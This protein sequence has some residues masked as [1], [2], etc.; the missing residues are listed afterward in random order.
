MRFSAADRE[1]IR[2]VGE[3]FAKNAMM[4]PRDDR[5]SAACYEDDAIML[6]PNQAPLNG[7]AAIE[8]FLSS[9]PPFSDYQLEVAEI[10]GDG[11]LAYERGSASMTLSASG[12]TSTKW[13]INYLIIWRRQPSGCW[14]VAREIFTPAAAPS[15][16]G[17]PLAHS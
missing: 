17:P 15:T 7:R 16:S 9:F 5:A 3:L 14:K 1:D 6:P 12:P 13:R 8:A 10:L 2:R 4:K 11:D